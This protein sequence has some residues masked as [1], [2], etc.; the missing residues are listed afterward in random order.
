VSP[1]SQIVLVYWAM[2]FITIFGIAAYCLVHVVPPPPP[3]NSDEQIARFFAEHSLSIRIGAVLAMSTTGFNIPLSAVVS[4]QMARLGRGMR[5]WSIVQ[6]MAGAL[7]SVWLVF[8]VLIWGVAAFTP[9]RAPG[10]TRMLSDLSF[11]ALVTTTPYF[12]F[13]VLAIAYVCLSQKVDSA[14]FPRWFGYLS[15][16]VFLFT[17]VGPLGFLTKTGPFAWNGLIVFWIPVLVFFSWF[18]TLSYVLI[19]ALSRESGTPEVPTP[20][21]VGT[22]G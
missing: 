17:E 3:T 11:L 14:Y 4:Y 20:C 8:P 22:P 1:R 7:V 16:W 2:A 19:R 6:G 12:I 15:L 21:D 13:Q 18:F 10:T 9:E 5:V